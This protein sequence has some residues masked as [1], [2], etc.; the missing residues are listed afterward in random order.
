M[1]IPRGRP[2]SLS[3]LT[4]TDRKAVIYNELNG[5][6]VQ[7]ASAQRSP[8]FYRAPIKD[9]FKWIKVLKSRWTPISFKRD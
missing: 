7:M 4:L 8:R 3:Q 1:V 5:P 6:E 9:D 2:S